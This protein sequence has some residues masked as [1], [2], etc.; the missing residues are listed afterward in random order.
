LQILTQEALI[1][2]AGSGPRA[3]RKEEGGVTLWGVGGSGRRKEEEESW[4]STEASLS[5]LYLL[6]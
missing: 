1:V 2:E 3:G 5:L 6:Y 4:K